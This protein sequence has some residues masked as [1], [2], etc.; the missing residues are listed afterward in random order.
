MLPL[1]KAVEK[2][3]QR[4]EAEFRTTCDTT[5]IGLKQHDAQ[6]LS[7]RTSNVDTVKERKNK[8]HVF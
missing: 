2:S 3:Q 7:K 5:S 6:E 1:S 4:S 8:I